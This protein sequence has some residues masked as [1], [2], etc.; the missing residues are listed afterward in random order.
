[1]VCGVNEMSAK[2]FTTKE[3]NILEQVAIEV[4]EFHYEMRKGVSQNKYVFVVPANAAYFDNAA[5]GEQKVP[6]ELVGYWVMTF[7]SDL[8]YTRLNEAIKN[9]QWSRCIKKEIVSYEW[10][11]I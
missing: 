11:E 5:Y 6:S 9:D 3:Y 7:A 10:E 4:E 2:H 1:M 8:Q